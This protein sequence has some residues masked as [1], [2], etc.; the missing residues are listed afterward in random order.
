MGFEDEREAVDLYAAAG[1]ELLAALLESIGDAPKPSAA[2]GWY[3]VHELAAHAAGMSDTQI[4]ER[5][6]KGVAAG[7]HERRRWANTIYY[8]VRPVV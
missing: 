1:D 8:R 2:D 7:S 5:L 4:R 6:E 3:T